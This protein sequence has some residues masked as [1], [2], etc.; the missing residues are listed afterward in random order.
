MDKN[1]IQQNILEEL[2]LE[3]L[4]EDKKEELLSVM[5]ESVLKRITISVL[6][7]LSDE[8]KKEFDKLR[9]QADAEKINQFL[10][11]KIENYDA[12]IEKI[13][14]E[15]KQEMQAT[16]SELEKDIS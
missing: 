8:D 13:I 1:K 3:N 7:Q 2:G 11:E 16:M 14:K 10:R 12:M 9:D 15:F 5:T 4:P 6:E